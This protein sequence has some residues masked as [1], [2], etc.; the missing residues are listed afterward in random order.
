MKEVIEKSKQLIKETNDQS[1]AELEK[2]KI[3]L[4]AR[5]QLFGTSFGSI[6]AQPYATN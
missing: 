4:E 5:K 6:G 3:E 1:R 2:L